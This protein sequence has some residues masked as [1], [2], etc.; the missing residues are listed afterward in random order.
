MPQNRFDDRCVCQTN[1][2][3]ISFRE[4]GRSIVFRNPRRDEYYK[5]RIDGCVITE[6]ER[7]DDFLYGKEDP[8]DRYVE[9]KGS[10]IP[11]AINQLRSS[12]IWVKR[13]CNVGK[14]IKAYIISKN[15]APG[16][17]TKLQ[18][19]KK[20]FNNMGAELIQKERRLETDLY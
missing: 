7:C 12:I 9:L 14:A 18:A 5:V 6:G 3:N 1:D 19:A 11:H 16:Y 20:E 17:N 10:D 4:N 2:S 13:H 8:Y 15:V